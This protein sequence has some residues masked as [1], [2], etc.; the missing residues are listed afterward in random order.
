MLKRILSKLPQK[1]SKCVGSDC[2][3]NT[4]GSGKGDEVRCTSSGSVALNGLK[5][6]KKVSAA[7]FPTSFAAGME[8]VEPHVSFN[9]VPNAIKQNL[10]LSKL[11]YCCLVQDSKGQG[12]DSED[13]DRKRQVLLELVEFVSSGSAKFTESAVS[14]LFKVC[15]VNLFRV[16]PPKDRSAFGGGEAEKEEPMYDPAWTHI[17]LVYDLLLHF[18]SHNSLDMKVSKKYID[19]SFISR[20]IDLFDSEDARERDCL[21]TILH[22][23]YAKFMIHRPFI[24]KSISNVIYHFVFETERH[25]GIAE[26]LEIFG[27]VISGF[28]LPLSGEHRTFLLRVLMPLHKPKSIGAYHQ[29]LSYCIVQFIEKEQGLAKS[30]LKGLLKY[31]PVTNSQKELM[32]LSE[33]E[34]VLESSS[35]ADFQEVMVPLFQRVTSCLTSSHYQ[36]AERAHLLWNNK[37][38]RDFVMPNRHVLL[39]I[40][41]PALELNTNSHWNR[42]V[43]NLTLNLKKMLC[44]MDTDLVATCQG[45]NS[46]EDSTESSVEVSEEQ[47]PTHEFS[48]PDANSRPSIVKST[49]LV[50]LVAC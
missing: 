21:K 19:C 18:I 4:Q 50:E 28:S 10:F 9:D 33:L 15:A 41:I 45:N 22:R 25:N 13:Y 46:M 14:V 49:A 7:I 6:F 1:T 34:E 40:V 17:Q 8:L 2:D 26:L 23:I 42:A 5:V 3:I 37:H 32:F 30:V 36:V 39:P 16:F 48:I 47:I 12:S 11:N 24:R 31:W 27:C 29:E 43:L 38:I 35:M 44:E 20:L